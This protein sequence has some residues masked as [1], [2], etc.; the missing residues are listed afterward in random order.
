MATQTAPHLSGAPPAGAH[1]PGGEG[2]AASATPNAEANADASQIWDE[3]KAAMRA[4]ANEKQRSTAVEIAEFARAL[5]GASRS[6]AGDGPVARMASQSADTLERLSDTLQNR[7][8]DG[9]VREVQDFA[10]TQPAM[11][12][13]MAVAAGFLATRFLSSSAPQRPSSPVDQ[14]GAHAPSARSDPNAPYSAP[15]ADATPPFPQDPRRK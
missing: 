12:L 11:F 1:R 10:R 15:S 5:R 4:V 9:V 8:F 13:G 3:A 7:D 2:S 14:D 6:I